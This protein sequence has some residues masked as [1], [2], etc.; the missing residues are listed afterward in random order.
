MSVVTRIDARSATNN[1]LQLRDACGNV[2]ATIETLTPETKLRI[3]TGN[4]MSI[5]KSNGTV[6]KRK[7]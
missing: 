3:D 7:Q 6:I 1:S 2:L 5:V 4:G